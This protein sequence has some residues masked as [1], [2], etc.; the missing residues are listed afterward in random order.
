MLFVVSLLLFFLVSAVF[1][2][3]N[4]ENPQQMSG[5]FWI[6]PGAEIALYGK[7]GPAYG[8]S[9]AVG[10][11]SGTSIGIKAAYFYDPEDLTIL[12]I[13]FQLRW[14]FM[15][16]TTNGP[17]IQFGCGPVFIAQGTNPFDTTAN[18]ASISAALYIGWRI[19][20]GSRFF[21]EPNI[22][23]GYPFFAG[24]SLSAGLNF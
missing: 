18:T 20:L 16:R 5:D 14:Y 22:R 11:G 19:P 8:G 24:A 13:N 4:V 23:A 17:F 21:L 12:E 10:Y 1:S 15:G 9:I 7:T 6:S 2:Q 3:E